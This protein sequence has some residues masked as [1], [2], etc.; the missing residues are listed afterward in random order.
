[1]L[2]GLDEVPAGLEA[3]NFWGYSTH[4][5]SKNNLSE[6][7]FFYFN[8]IKTKQQ[9]NVAFINLELAESALTI[10]RSNLRYS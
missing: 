7:V 5:S 4:Y 2:S 8:I 3:E 1:M 6:I 10:C 9:N